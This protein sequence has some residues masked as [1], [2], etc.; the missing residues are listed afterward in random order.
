MKAYQIGV[1]LVALIGVL[2]FQLLVMKIRKSMVGLKMSGAMSLQVKNI[3]NNI[4]LI[5]KNFGNKIETIK[6]I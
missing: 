3:V 1:L 4:I 5:G 2:K 6:Y